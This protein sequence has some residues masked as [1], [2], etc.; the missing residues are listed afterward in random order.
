MCKKIKFESGVDN[1]TYGA[2]TCRRK[3]YYHKA[4]HYRGLN[5]QSKQIAVHN[6]VKF[7]QH[8]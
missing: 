8:I 7:Q 5:H 3:I 6:S 1:M 4:R 2:I